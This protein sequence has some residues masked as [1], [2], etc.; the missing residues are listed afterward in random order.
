MQVAILTRICQL[1]GAKFPLSP[2]ASPDN[3]TIRLNMVPMAKWEAMHVIKPLLDEVLELAS[4]LTWR[5]LIS[6]LQRD[7]EVKWTDV[8]CNTCCSQTCGASKHL[9][10]PAYTC[11]AENHHHGGEGKVKGGSKK[12]AKYEKE[13]M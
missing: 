4:G 9:M 6:T 3:D 8:F 10:K 5:S 7:S 1:L 13:A 2:V 11:L 12:E